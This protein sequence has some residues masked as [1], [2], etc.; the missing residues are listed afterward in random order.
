[1]L[2][3]PHTNAL[4]HLASTELHA[5]QA[6]KREKL[7][8]IAEQREAF[9]ARLLRERDAGEQQL[10][11]EM[12]AKMA[13]MRSTMEAKKSAQL[14]KL[15]NAQRAEEERH[16][17]ELRERKEQLAQ[18]TEEARQAALKD[19]ADKDKAKHQ[20]LVASYVDQRKKIIDST[21]SDLEE[22]HNTLQRKLANRKR[23]TAARKSVAM[24]QHTAKMGLL[25]TDVKKV[26]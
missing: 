1:M 8:Q 6:E 20:T 5:L 22:H 7:L 11:R 25:E 9:E 10:E 16:A 26:S 2:T 18:E 17:N 19:Q 14:S 24:G 12:E 4:T 15:L 13:E 3:H 23:R 21:R